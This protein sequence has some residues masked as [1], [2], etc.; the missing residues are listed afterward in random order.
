MRNMH[1][2]II[3]TLKIPSIDSPKDEIIIFMSGFL[4][5]I[6]N[7]LNVLI[8]F[9]IERSIP[10]LMSIIAVETM[11]KSNF[12]QEFFRYALSPIINP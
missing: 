7:G 8:S 3:N 1:K 4:E 11:K 10:T 2:M 5:I 12:D 6:L 9:K